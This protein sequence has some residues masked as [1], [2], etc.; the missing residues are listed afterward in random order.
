MVNLPWV[1]WG[2]AHGNKTGPAGPPAPFKVTLSLLPSSCC[3]SIRAQL[4]AGGPGESQLLQHKP[5]DPGAA[6]H[7][8]PSFHQVSLAPQP[9]PWP[10]AILSIVGSYTAVPWVLQNVTLF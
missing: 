2:A 6:V 9:S 3:N 5:G 1:L 7:H 4:L 10:Q 8:V